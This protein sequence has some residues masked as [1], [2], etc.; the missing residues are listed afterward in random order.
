M[1]IWLFAEIVNRVLGEGQDTVA[2]YFSPA[3]PVCGEILTSSNFQSLLTSYKV[4]LRPVGLPEHDSA[5]QAKVS[6]LLM[7]HAE[8]FLD[9]ERLFYQYIDLWF[10]HANEERRIEALSDAWRLEIPEDIEADDRSIY[11]IARKAG[12]PHNEIVSVLND[13]AGIQTMKDNMSAYRNPDLSSVEVIPRLEHP[14]FGFV[15]A[16]NVQKK[17]EE[18]LENH[19]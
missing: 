9:A 17:I 6:L 7:Y 16:Q 10:S 3:C 5:Q 19:V 4:D 8:N 13:E 12:I 2:L 11:L 14:S 1:I 18:L 15:L